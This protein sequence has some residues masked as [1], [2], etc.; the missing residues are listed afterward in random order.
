MLGEGFI[1]QEKIDIEWEKTISQYWLFIDK[2][3]G[4]YPISKGDARAFISALTDIIAVGAGVKDIDG[5]RWA[6]REALKEASKERL[7]KERYT[8]ILQKWV[9]TDRK[10]LQALLSHSSLKPEWHTTKED[11]NLFVIS[12]FTGSYGLDLGFEYAGFRVMVALDS[13]PASMDILK[14][15]RPQI[16]F[17]CQDI[18]NTTTREILS[19]A[20]LSVGE[21]DVLTGGPP[22]QPFSTGGKRQGLRDP[23]ASPLKEFIRV[24]NEAQPKAFVMEEVTG[25]L[26]TRLS[27][28]PIKERDRKLRPDELPGSVWRIVLEELNKTGYRITWKVLN[29]ADFGTP[30]TRQRVIVI[31]LRPDLGIRPSMPVATHM[32]P[33]MRTLFGAKPWKC[34]LDV[35]VGINVGEFVELPPKYRKYMRYIPPGGNWRQI[36]GELLPDAMNGA[37]MAGGGGMGFYRRLSWFEPSP[38]LVTSPIMKGSMLIH[39]VEDR[40]LS[41]NEY[42]VIQGFPQ[43]WKT[44][45]PVTVQ[46]RKIGEAVPPLLSFAIATILKQLLTM[47]EK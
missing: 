40:P 27:H 43:D 20:G 19:T 13:D 42:K 36:P 23:R 24:I 6:L 44:P 31:G 10:S 30:Q 3:R 8:H 45:G 18:S 15:N 37:F 17:I 25:I 14:A 34:L 9:V 22:C 4:S 26:N 33:G 16:P 38:T 12:L 46:Y 41:V 47:Q 5:L 11:S 2:F 29:A 1:L 21:V 7:N 39:P 28:V 32:K 35:L